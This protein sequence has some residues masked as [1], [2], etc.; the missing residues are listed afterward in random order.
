MSEDLNQTCP[1]ARALDRIGDRWSLLIVRDAFDGVRRFSDFQRGL[2]MSRSMLSQ[3]LQAL[4]DANVLTQQAAAD[5]S[6]YHDYVLTPQGQALFP[7][8]VALRQWGE[9]YLLDRGDQAGSGALERRL[10]LE[11]KA[12]GCFPDLSEQ[13]RVA[14]K[15]VEKVE[16]RRHRLRLAR[17]ISGK[18]IGAA[19]CD[20]RGLVLTQAQLST[21][22]PQFRAGVQSDLVHQVIGGSKIAGLAGVI[23]KPLFAALTALTGQVGDLDQP[24]AARKGQRAGEGNQ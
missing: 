2:G 21:H 8:V 11:L 24:T 12:G 16:Y 20:G 19:P 1:V 7:L 9:G 17:F 6:R 22:P 4:Q 13:V 5:G 23:Q 3:R 14:I 10:D 15:K 18:C